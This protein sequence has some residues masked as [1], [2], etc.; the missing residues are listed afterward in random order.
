ME[1][2]LRGSAAV[3][4]MVRNRYWEE[5]HRRGRNAPT[6]MPTCALHGQRAETHRVPRPWMALRVPQRVASWFVINIGHSFWKEEIGIFQENNLAQQTHRTS[7]GSVAQYENVLV[8]VT[9][10]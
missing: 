8:S 5:D 7:R 9:Q 1:T 10:R 3:M 6:A 4:A 2:G